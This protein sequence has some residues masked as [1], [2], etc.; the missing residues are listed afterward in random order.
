MLLQRQSWP[1]ITPLFADTNLLV[2]SRDARDAAKLQ[3]AREWLDFLWDT[4]RGR[5]SRQ[6]LHE[7]Y[8]TVTRKLQP[9]LT[10]AEARADVRSLFHWLSPIDPSVLMEAAWALQDRCSLSFW[11]AL[12]VGAAQTMGCGFVLTEDLPAGQDLEGVHVVNPFEMRPADLP[13]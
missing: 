9:G 1:Y 7:Y 12:I 3:R 6:V 13:D 8:V 11:D 5:L 10:V 4:R 2:S